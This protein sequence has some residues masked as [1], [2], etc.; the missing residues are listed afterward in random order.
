MSYPQ[1]SEQKRWLSRP[2]KPVTLAE[3]LRWAGDNIRLLSAQEARLEAELL[4]AHVLSLSRAQLY[5]N[6]ADEFPQS[7]WDQFSSILER[8]AV[9]PVAYITNAKEFYGREFYVDQRVLVPRPETETLVE[10]ALATAR[11]MQADTSRPPK[12]ADIGAGSGVIAITLALALAES[13]VYAVDISLGALEVAAINSA[14]HG[15]LYKVA[16]LKGDL[17]APLPE[18]VDMIVANLPYVTQE[19][20]QQAGADWY[21]ASLLAEPRSALYGGHDGLEVIQ[22]LIESAPDH[23]TS[24]GA[25]ILETGCHQAG[26]ALRM[27]AQRFPGASLA[28]HRDLSGLDRVVSI[29]TTGLEE[30]G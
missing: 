18:K 25:L 28:V 26:E 20:L 1:I 13:K 27:A 23:L 17:T 2:P 6:L 4:L 11:R 3:A 21:T 5:A 30:G 10:I 29:E 24:G 8:R 15:T 16:L 9:E 19:E 12:I 7:S 22:R 14:R